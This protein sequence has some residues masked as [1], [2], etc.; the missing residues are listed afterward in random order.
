MS[1]NQ[2]PLL[3]PAPRHLEPHSGTFYVPY[4][5]RIVLKETADKAAL[6]AARRLQ[7]T[8]E[9][10]CSLTLP[11]SV[12]ARAEVSAAFLFAAD[13]SLPA[14]G[15]EIRIGSEG[16][17]IAYGSPEGAFY[18][19]STLKQ[20]ALQCGRAFPCL[21]IRDEPDFPAR[22]VML[23]ISRNKIP[24]TD[25]LHRIVDLMADLKLNQLQL[26]IEGLPFA[27]ESFPQAWE[28]ETP[29]SGDEIL[30]LDEYCRERY[31]DLVPN[32]N[33]FG[34]MEEWLIR[35]E[36]NHLAE[37]PEGFMMPEDLYST[38]FSPKGLYMRP[39][40]FYTGEPEVFRLLERMYDD[41][42]PYFSSSLFNAGL[43]E[44]FE[45][46]LGRSK[47][48]V[49]KRG[50]GEVY[51]DFLLKVYEL[52]K[53]RGKTM[54]FWGDIILQHPE[55]IPRLPKDLVAME[56][57]YHAVHPFEEHTQKFREAGIP[58]YVCPGT[59]AWN[60]LTGQADNAFGNLRNAAVHGRNNGAIGY[61]ITDWGDHG[62]WQ[63]LPVSYPGYVYGAAVS[64]NVD[65]NLNADTAG[66]LDRFV[67]KDQSEEAGRLLIDLGN[68]YK[69]ESDIMRW[70]DTEMS[71]LLRTDLDNVVI[72]EQLD[73]QKLEALGRYIDEI[74]G[75]L[76]RLSLRCDDA[77]LVMREL[78]NGIR[79]VRH[80]V[81]LG[82]LKRGLAGQPGPALAREAEVLAHDLDGLLHEYRQLWLSRNRLGG[83]DKSVSRL[84]RLRREY[85]AFAASV[86][87][88]AKGL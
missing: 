55:L 68:Y 15:Y 5:S 85:A 29:I 32:Q 49:E 53:Q 7:K 8:L 12:P 76:D 66:Y 86:E 84:L 21:L 56:W 34:H 46:G 74:E 36:F 44:T 27:Y 30:R 83:L 51:L 2:T 35:P 16:V 60:S 63:H 78:Q 13:A 11:I 45:L 19:V 52:V 22:G 62:H 82:L 1:F 80:A 70:N 58:F 48:E 37:T 79:F 4:A 77:G 65:G 31:I 47:E 75:R 17:Q 64:W 25:T 39:G 59:S 3:M 33:S 38:D 54:Q 40:T 50:A 88:G 9:D 87:G 72:V 71:M 24:T 81:R 20:I 23:D 10:S 26:Y 6:P 28:L 42:L 41:L 57:G 69:L 73:E 61:L 67:F 18:A 14:Q 43:D